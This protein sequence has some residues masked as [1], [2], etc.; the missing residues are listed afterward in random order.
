M[1]KISAPLNTHPIWP[2]LGYGLKND[3]RGLVAQNVA[4][5]FLSTMNLVVVGIGLM[6]PL[7]S[8]G[9]EQRH[10]E[11]TISRVSTFD[12]IWP[13]WFGIRNGTPGLVAQNVSWGSLSNAQGSLSYPFLLFLSVTHTHTHSPPSMPPIFLSGG[14][15]EGYFNKI[16]FYHFDLQEFWVSILVETIKYLIQGPSFMGNHVPIIH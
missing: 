10:H 3:T 2:G 14:G 13:G 16:K 4:P 15:R 5:S 8:F 9:T 6:V 12:P 1:A 11:G 7:G